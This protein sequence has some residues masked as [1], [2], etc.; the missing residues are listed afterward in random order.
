MPRIQQNKEFLKYADLNSAL[1]CFILS[2]FYS[3]VLSFILIFLKE[4]PLSPHLL[5][6]YKSVEDEN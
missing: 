6:I 2:Y 1:F 5:H 4:Q 3:S